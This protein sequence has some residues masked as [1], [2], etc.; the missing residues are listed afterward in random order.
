MFYDAK[1]QEKTGL[2]FQTPTLMAYSLI[3]NIFLTLGEEYH[4]RRLMYLQ[5]EFSKRILGR[6]TLF[7]PIRM[8][9]SLTLELCI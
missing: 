4:S 6:P 8:K 1:S 5:D 9:Y 3:F 7:L 2:P